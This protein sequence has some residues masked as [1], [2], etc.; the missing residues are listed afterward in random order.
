MIGHNV[1]W[2]NIPPFCLD[3]TTWFGRDN[4]VWTG[5]LGLDGTAWFGRDNLVWTGQM[6][7]SYPPFHPVTINLPLALECFTDLRVDLLDGRRRC[8]SMR[9]SLDWE[10][11]L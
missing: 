9:L 2:T 4:L 5:Q 7:P 1:I 6:V 10:V 3:G 8:D 11:N